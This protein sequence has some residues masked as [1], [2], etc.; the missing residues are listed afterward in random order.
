MYTVHFSKYKQQVAMFCILKRLWLGKTQKKT[1]FVDQPQG[2]FLNWEEK[3]VHLKKIK[4]VVCEI[5]NH[6]TKKKFC[7]VL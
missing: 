6:A 2:F 7:V 4:G 5:T 1:L 3:I